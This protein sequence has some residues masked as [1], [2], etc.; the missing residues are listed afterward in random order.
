VAFCVRS[1]SD[2]RA[3]P[4]LLHRLLLALLLTYLY[5][6]PPPCTLR[7]Q[8]WFLRCWLRRHLLSRDL[9]KY[10]SCCRGLV[11]AAPPLP[12]VV[13]TLISPLFQITLTDPPLAAALSSTPYHC[14]FTGSSLKSSSESN[15]VSMT[16]ST[17][18]GVN[19]F[20]R[21]FFIFSWCASSI[22]L[23][24][25]RHSNAFFSP[26]ADLYLQVSDVS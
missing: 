6:R 16:M 11:V 23:W 1:D 5:C 19:G 14:S 15:D 4:P 26:F 7:S 18:M 2:E 13:R 17:G 20:G 21:K 8:S 25:R 22:L 12:L 24:L 10:D 3:N 9:R